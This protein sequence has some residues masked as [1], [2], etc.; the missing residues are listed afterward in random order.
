M[1]DDFVTDGYEE[2]TATDWIEFTRS[3]EQLIPEFMRGLL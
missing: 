2:R 3:T 1:W